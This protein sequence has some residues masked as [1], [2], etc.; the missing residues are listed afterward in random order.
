MK[1][2]T[3]ILAIELVIVTNSCIVIAVAFTIVLNKVR[4]HVA[5]CLFSLRH[6]VKMKLTPGSST[7]R[8]VVLICA[9]IS[10]LNLPVEHFIQGIFA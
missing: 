6:F 8:F 4:R 2:G 1:K 7:Q 9:S 3:L 10:L 5:S